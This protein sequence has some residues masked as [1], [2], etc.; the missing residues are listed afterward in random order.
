MAAAKKKAD[1]VAAGKIKNELRKQIR[2]TTKATRYKIRD[3]AKADLPKEG[4]LN[5]WA[6]RVPSASVHTQ[7]KR[8]G[9]RLRL[10]RR[11]ADMRALNR[12]VA[13]H[14][15]FGNKK[16]WRNTYFKDKARWFDRAAEADKP[17]LVKEMQDGI[18]AAIEAHW[19]K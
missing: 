14:P 3:A 10:T 15:V 9:V 6:A 4:G 16:V 17:R 5:K 8:Q 2:A 13:R 12:G 19:R 11:G 7:G 1:L 18:A